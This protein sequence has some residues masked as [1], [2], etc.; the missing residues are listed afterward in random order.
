MTRPAVEAFVAEHLG[1]LVDGTVSGSP[2]IRGGQR[3]ADAALAG[4]D[5]TGYANQRNEVAPINRRGASRL[6]PYIRHG[7][8]TLGQ[9]WDAVAGGPERD[10]QKFRD[11]LLWQ[12]YARHWYARIGHASARPLRRRPATTEPGDGW[13][14]MLPC[15][16]AAVTEL[17]HDG[18]LV[19]QARMWLASDWT[20]RHGQDWRRGE[21]RF[22]R[23][24]LDG[25]RAANR[26][27]WQWTTGL[28]SSKSYGFSRYQVE[29]RA[30]GYCQQCPYRTA[31]PIEDWPDDRPLESVEWPKEVDLTGPDRRIANSE[32]DTV[33]LTAE[34]LGYSDPALVA[35]P[36]LPAAFVF[37][38][39]LLARLRL[40]AKRLVFLTETLV[41]L[42]EVRPVE[43]HLGDP[44]VELRGRSLAVTHAPVPGFQ[45]RASALHPAETHPWPWLRA[46]GPG[47]VKSFSAWR[48]RVDRS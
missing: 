43:L 9:V 23:H 4:F 33:W 22:F 12:E 14:R 8:L 16:N 17:E 19:N 38:E 7:L 42:A 26:L 34:S 15:L 11:E 10:V 31:C 24:L 47:S 39:P 40:D 30:P 5:V 29:R 28:G 35:N 48:K 2:S 36:N 44:T 32:P 3:S 27:G 45:T 21:D 13:D 18:W 25:S 6:S 41:E 37:D 46:P 1:H 20:V